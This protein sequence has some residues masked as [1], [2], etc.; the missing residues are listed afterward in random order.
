MAEF[1]N[2]LYQVSI[3]AENT[4]LAPGVTAAFDM[5]S[6]C[7]AEPNGNIGDSGSVRVVRGVR[8]KHDKGVG[9][10]DQLQIFKILKCFRNWIK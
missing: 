9:V 5:L 6:F 4:V 10:L 8:F 3:K 7:V 2:Q 1:V